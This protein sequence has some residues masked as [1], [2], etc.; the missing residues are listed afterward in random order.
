MFELF[1]IF[2][3]VGLKTDEAEKGLDGIT[4][5]A[6][7]TAGGITG[8]FKDIGKGAAKLAGAIGITQLV[9]AGINAI[10]SSVAG[11]VS[12]VDTLNQFPR[13]L[14]QMGVE[15]D[16]A[17][18][19][20]ARLSDGIQGLPTTLDGIA[21]Q[22]QRMFT[23]LGDIDLATE[24]TLAL[25]NAFLASGASQADA[26]RGLEQYTQMLSSGKVDMQS[27]RTLQETMP[28]ALK[29]TA[30]AFGFTGK[31]AT[32]DF[33][34]ALQD[35]DITMDEMNAKLIELSNETGGFAETALEASKGIATS[36]TN[37]KTA[38]TT[39]VAN[40]VA[41]FDD[42]LESEGFGGIAGV[43]DIVKVKT[44]E[45]FKTIAEW[46]P[47][48]IDWFSDLYT[49][50]S[51][52]TAWQTL[53]DS[54]SSIIETGN[55]LITNFFESQAWETIKTTLKDLANAI[56][57]IDF[58]ELITQV[59]DFL[60]KWSPLI[61]GIVGAMGVFKAL[62]TVIPIVVSA[63]KTF[64]ILK[65]LISSVGLLQTGIT[66]LAPAMFVLTSPITWIA[67]AI[68]A[69]IA[70]GVL[71]YKNW[72]T[73]KEKA[74]ELG[75]KIAEVWNNIKT[76]TSETWDGI[77]EYLS[78][79]WAGIMQSASEFFTPI[80]EF[81][82]ELWTSVT[83]I[84]QTAWD[85]ILAV[86]E[87]AWLLLIEL[88]NLY[89]DILMI[90]WNFLWENFSKPLT[91]AWE[92]IKTYLSE[93][94]EVISTWFSEKWTAIKDFTSDTW[95]AVK[96]NIIKPIQEAWDDLKAKIQEIWTGITTKWE[97]IKTSTK[98]KW[99]EV[100]NSIVKPVQEA[101]NNLKAKVQEI[102]T[103]ILG[104]WNE[105]KADATQK[106]NETKQA[107]VKPIQEAW[108]SLRAK[109]QEIKSGITS[110][111]NETKTSVSKTWTDIKT[112]ITK[113]ITDAWNKVK[114]MINKIKGAMNFKWSLPKLKMP[115][116][117]IS[118]KFSLAPPSV[119]KLGIEWYKDGGILT[120]AMAFGMNG[121]DIMVGGEAGKE[122]VL[123]LNRE[124]LGGI[125][126]G[127]ASTMNLSNANIEAI[128]LDIKEQLMNLLSR[129]NTVVV[130][131]DGRT[132]AR[133]TSSYLDE[134]DGQKTRNSRRGWV[135]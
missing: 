5:K 104:K 107:I 120:K 92:A 71:L 62:S 8:F 109:V 101:W 18:A 58:K 111:F 54:I 35:G 56:L 38:I 96:D 89:I 118:G 87:V 39:G 16:A 100:K 135:T 79:L 72:D 106:W 36:W 23:I 98:Q 22:T 129:N 122:A 6:K 2:G 94:L 31:S 76:W 80:G 11:A 116:F 41:A 133:V 14:K 74:A 121:N 51:E 126:Q 26:T 28:Y 91:E 130:Q 108:N 115:H 66:L 7:K 102:K 95:T 63:F 97:E 50:V 34:A 52:S 69:L 99:N 17:D 9:A 64:S 61:I 45:A 128:L 131:L 84:F 86:L 42:W 103:G 78:E 82:S 127:I 46:V 19:S 30:E 123:P 90:P 77:K 68:G 67:V 48:A 15:G 24:S 70:I 124:T 65:T 81:F 134:I 119:P 37:I 49:K 110:R 47:K 44:Q 113:P 88:F 43:L 53:T 12:R 40:I 59:G 3:T 60:D 75:E 105:I 27:W 83:E 25:N 112:S 85:G 20:I 29:E 21:G 4:G 55:E 125:G 1:K 13:V 117:N 73:I 32:N 93:T 114:E 10:R 33:Y 132:I 57:E